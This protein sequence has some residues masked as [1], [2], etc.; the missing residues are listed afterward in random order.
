[1]FI[2]NLLLLTPAL[3][4]KLLWKILSK[5]KTV[6]LLDVNVYA[7]KWKEKDVAT[8]QDSSTKSTSFSYAINRN[9]SS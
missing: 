8:G 7:L 4:K 5:L 3:F 6:F 9:Q 1:M 2:A